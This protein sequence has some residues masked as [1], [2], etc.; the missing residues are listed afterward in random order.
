MKT[1]KSTATLIIAP[2]G[3]IENHEHDAE[4][5]QEEHAHPRTISVEHVKREADFLDR[6]AQTWP[7]AGS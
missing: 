3:K 5:A 6:M 2:N 4:P 1:T 7:E